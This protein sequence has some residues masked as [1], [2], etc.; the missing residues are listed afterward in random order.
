MKT[1]YTARATTTGGR[2]GTVA[3]DDKALSLK[4]VRPGTAGAAGTNPEQLFAAGYSACFTSAVE[5]IAKKQGQNVAPVT[6]NI[7]VN[8]N[9]DET[10][11]FSLN[12]TL[13]VQLPSLDQA[14]AEKLVAAAHQMCPYSKAT[15]GNMQVTLKANGKPLAANTAAAA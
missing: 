9:Q 6:T 1:L 14:A 11:G 8:L 5:G 4:L 2:D 10:T 13:D 7:E 3:T 15:R 12:A